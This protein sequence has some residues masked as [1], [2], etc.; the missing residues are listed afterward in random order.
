MQMI[1]AGP[2]A[3]ID[4]YF[5]YSEPHATSGEALDLGHAIRVKVRNAVRTLL[6][7]V[8]P[9]GAGRLVGAGAGLEASRERQRRG[10]RHDAARME[11]RALRSSDYFA[12]SALPGLTS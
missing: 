3:E 8:Q 7:A 2:R 4:R 10:S 12:L 1:P 9:R 6:D 5:G 11:V